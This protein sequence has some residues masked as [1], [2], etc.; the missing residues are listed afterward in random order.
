M[1]NFIP[2][3]KYDGFK[4]MSMDEELLNDSIDNKLEPSLRLYGWSKPTITLGRN[5]SECGIN[6]D[7]CA[8]NGIDIVRRVTGGRAV[9]HDKE[10]TY[11][12]IVPVS[13]LKNGNSVIE[14]YKQ[15]SQALINAFQDLGIELSYP[16]YKKVSVKNEYCMA[17]STVADLC[18]KGKK[19]IGSAQFRKH[20]YILQHGSILL[21]VNKSILE[22]IF[23]TA[24][25]DKNLIT[26]KE[27]N[28]RLADI[29]VLSASLNKSFSLLF[30]N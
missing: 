13:Y 8:K 11:C 23:D 18:Y 9:L 7:F 6:Q 24:E 25:P 19:L 29:E 1:I 17:I 4:N 16:E 28:E 27:I 3:S 15:I 5:Q 30:N 21:D 26:L 22:G 2:Y 10:L 12:F 20:D 14:S